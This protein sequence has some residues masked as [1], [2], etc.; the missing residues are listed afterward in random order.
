MNI[1]TS[2]LI[3]ISVISVYISPSK[4]WITAL[5][6][7][8]YKFFSLAGILFIVTWIFV[9][10]KYVLYSI[11]LFLPAFWQFPVS[12]QLNMSK[13]SEPG[14]VKL[15]TYNVWNFCRSN[16]IYVE[17]CL[18]DSILD[19]T[20]KEKPD[21]LC[22]QEFALGKG[23]KD[24][25][26]RNI[27]TQFQL[28]YYSYA[29]Y[30]KYPRDVSGLVTFSHYPILH[31]DSLKN[32]SRLTY[33]QIS[34]ILIR[35]RVVR[36]INVQLSSNRLNASDSLYVIDQKLDNS[37]IKNTKEL[38]LTR[39]KNAYIERETQIKRICKIIKFSPYPVVLVGDFNDT[40]VSYVYH[41]A[42]KLL[43]DAYRESGCGFCNTY[44]GKKAPAFRIDY[45]LYDKMMKSSNFRVIKSQ[46]SDHYP[47]TVML[48][49]R[50]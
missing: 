48:G 8:T 2:F 21:I 6:G 28:K 24:T 47:M 14:M 23:S 41:Q 42:S 37:M 11:F 43:T 38:F 9:N 20:Q 3:L 30:L 32:G 33:A 31:Y 13:K 26:I 46:L 34:D 50:Y 29:K 12:F 40:P 16:N 4:F 39:L 5:F 27:G 7:L 45:V 49:F 25:D 19:V 10:R 17:P 22:F 35:N 44:C 1:L 18:R 15:M 36:I